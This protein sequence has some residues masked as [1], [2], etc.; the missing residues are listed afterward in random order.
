MTRERW[1]QIK[2][3]YERI[4]SAPFDMRDSLLEPLCNGDSELRNEVLRMLRV[5]S[6]DGFIQRVIQESAESITS[7][8]PQQQQF[9]HYNVVRR[10]GSGG[11][12]V[13]Y[14]A[15]RVDDFKKRVALKI[16]KQGFD[17]DYARARVQQERQVLASLEHPY[18]ARLID[19]GETEDGGPYLVLEFVDGV[20]IDIYAAPLNRNDKLR[21]FLK[22][23]EAVE[24]AHRNLV[25]HRDLKPSNIFVTSG[26]EPRLLDFGIAKLLDPAATSTQTGLLAMTPDYASPEQVRGKQISTATD[27][28]S[29]GVVLYNLLT[30]RRPYSFPSA[31]PAEID[32]AVCETEPEAPGVSTDLDNI[33]LMALRK[34]PE[35]RYGSVEQFADDIRRYLENLP[36][37]ARADTFWYRTG[38]YA[39]RHWVGMLSAGIAVAGLL[40]GSLV[41]IQQARRAERR[42]LQVRTMANK[43]L[44]DFNDDIQYIPGTTKAREHMVS[45]ARDLFDSLA[46]EAG[47][48][49]QLL[50]ELATSYR[51]V[52]AIQGRPHYAN[53]GQ[54]EKAL[55]SYNRSAAI[56][57]KLNRRNPTKDTGRQL[58]SLYS[59]RASLYQ[60]L[61]RP[62]EAM[63]SAT[64]SLTIAKRLLTS[65]PEWQ[66]YRLA[67]SSTT[68][69]ANLKLASRDTP[70]AINGYQEALGY[71]RKAVEANPSSEM[72]FSYA[73]A[74]EHIGSPLARSG[75]FS[76]ALDAY[77]QE[78]EIVDAL[79]QQSPGDSHVK[80][81]RLLLFQ[82][83]GN[84]WGTSEVASL[85][86]HDK[87]IENFE[88]MGKLAQEMRAADPHDKTA[89]S[90][91]INYHLKTANVLYNSASK[92][93]IEHDE[94]ALRLIDQLPAG[95]QRD[96]MRVSA[97]TDLVPG[98]GALG[99]FAKAH[100]TLDEGEA[101]MRKLT[102]NLA[103]QSD[104][105]RVLAIVY[106]RL[107]ELSLQ[108]R[109]LDRALEAGLHFTN[110]S[111]RAYSEHPESLFAL[112]DLSYGWDLLSLIYQEKSDWNQVIAWQR[113]KLQA[114][115]D[116]D[117]QRIPNPYSKAQREDAEAAIRAATSRTRMPRMRH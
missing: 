58:S 16:I 22:V 3:V 79:E 109:K 21:L 116:W 67:A 60:Y 53:L 107:A 48:D 12:G 50:T 13:V 66:D 32:K 103:I 33:L 86:Q 14:E 40:I 110:G 70:A 59:E 91:L 44:F 49:P 92:Q 74:L 84:V 96:Y 6:N 77:R 26:G 17:S 72:R 38:K 113:T 23:C 52:A 75:N 61:S 80:R 42:F 56:L 15:I 114:W 24:Y 51:R 95:P 97:L 25:I 88:K 36:V 99:Q 62:A 27:I 81:L 90:D 47:D 111:A 101:L 82:N 115:I 34:E 35:R 2:S 18:I 105:E 85:M 71:W 11:M 41:A 100:A 43:F 112:Y 64:Q 108:E 9:G 8:Q 94:D 93:A 54:S 5:D 20:P 87:A 117:R 65:S 68:E 76:G 102:G 55:D 30:G 63:R 4:D 37:R 45:T 104:P 46:A 89:L 19:G 78:S 28:Y 29:L 73:T 31:T 57:E 10:I 98:Y 7:S 106:C 69:I 83:I 1:Q 39:R